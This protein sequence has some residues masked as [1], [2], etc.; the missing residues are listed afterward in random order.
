M[1]CYVSI[2]L[3]KAGGGGRMHGVDLTLNVLVTPTHKKKE[4]GKEWVIRGDGWVYS[5]AYNVGF[6]DVYLSWTYE[7][8][9]K[10]VIFIEIKQLDSIR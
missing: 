8:P 1:Q 10:Y 5:T 4:G 6:T 9:Y 7:S 2:Q 3:S